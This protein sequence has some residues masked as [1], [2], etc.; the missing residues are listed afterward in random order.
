MEGKALPTTIT[1]E[2]ATAKEELLNDTLDERF[3]W[4]KDIDGIPFDFFSAPTR[5][6]SDRP[7]KEHLKE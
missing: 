2:E 5:G 4:L 7:K 3:P 6:S 1:E